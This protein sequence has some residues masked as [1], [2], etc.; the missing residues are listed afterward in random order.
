MKSILL[1]VTAATRVLLCIAGDVYGRWSVILSFPFPLERS[2]APL[3]GRAD[4]DPDV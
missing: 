2:G 3:D 4:L 1:A